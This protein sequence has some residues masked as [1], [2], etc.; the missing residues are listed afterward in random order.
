MDFE[1]GSPRATLVG[2]SERKFCVLAAR[3]CLNDRQ[4]SRHLEECKVTK[5]QTRV[6]SIAGEGGRVIARSAIRDADQA[7]TAQRAVGSGL[8]T[9]GCA[10]LPRSLTCSAGLSCGV[11][12]AQSEQRDHD[13][14]QA[15]QNKCEWDPQAEQIQQPFV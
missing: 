1:E 3:Q 6:C 10:I 13:H 2:G 14:C 8:G 11:R 12:L 4:S 5:A 15:D 7:R 9:A